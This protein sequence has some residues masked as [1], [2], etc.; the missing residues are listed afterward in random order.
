LSGR[1]GLLLV[2]QA[3]DNVNNVTSQ[4]V[5]QF[6]DLYDVVEAAPEPDKFTPSVPQAYDP[7]AIA[8]AKKAAEKEA[9]ERERLAKEQAKE[10]ERLAEI[11]AQQL[12]E[13]GRR[14][15]DMELEARDAEVKAMR[16]G[17]QKTIEEIELSHDKELVAITRWYEDLRQKRIDEAKK[18]YDAQKANEGK[19]FFESEEYKKASSDEAYTEQEKDILA[20]KLKAASDVY[21]HALEDITDADR[22]AMINYLSEYG[23]YQEK[24]LAIAEKYDDMISKAMTEGERKSLEK[25]KNEAL[26]QLDF[27]YLQKE[28]DWS[29]IFGDLDRVATG[30]LKEVRAQLQLLKK[31]ANYYKRNPDQIKVIEEAINRIN[32]ELAEK[33]GLFGGLIDSFKVY[34]DA[35]RAVTEAEEQ[36]ANALTD[37]EK[38]RARQGLSIAKQNLNSASDTKDKSVDYTI[39]KTKSL[40]GVITE[41]GNTEELSVAQLG[42][43]IS[44]TTDIFGEAAGKIGGIIGAILAILDSIGNQDIDE[45]AKRM[46]NKVFNAVGQAF[47]S[48]YSLLHYVA[49]DFL[50]A[51]ND[52]DE[53]IPKLITANEDLEAAIRANTEALEDA[54]IADIASVY[55]NAVSL[56]NEREKNMRTIMQE[57]GSTYSSGFLGLGGKH[58]AFSHIDELMN[59]SEWARISKIVGKQVTSAGGFFTLSSE[60]MKKVREQASD[61][62]SK[63]KNAGEDGFAGIAQYMDEYIEYFEEFTA[64]QEKYFTK[65]TTVSLD[66]VVEDFRSSL[67][68]MDTNASDFADKF[69]EYMRN[70]I[71][72][73]LVTNQ[74]EPM[75]KDW[76]E[77]FAK[78]VETDGIDEAE[79]AALQEQWDAITEEGLRMRDQLRDQFGLGSTGEGSGL[80]KAVSSFSQEQGDELNGRLA[81][82]QIG[83]QYAN[84]QLTMAI[85]SLQGLSVVASANSGTIVE[86]RNLMLIGN[87]HLEDIARYTRIAAQ[88]GDAIEQIATK[89]KEL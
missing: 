87:S 36:L 35:V 32:A 29:V 65:L 34:E 38:E 30:E 7:K 66:S 15:V 84:E 80:Y 68:D 58:S 72:N 1:K 27:D 26:S 39:S 50:G 61:L 70:A 47:D 62:Y 75:L 17:T 85:A 42:N 54:S 10:R 49:G 33:G 3:M 88:Y 31:D 28:M 23:T 40:M 45:W 77:A 82:I 24:R 86:M 76:Y 22:A 2:A 69:E 67:A 56:M 78:A 59:A 63:I 5:K 13:E 41:L 60:D 48:K 19:N 11:Y 25:Q 71:I 9:K 20:R 6:E 14:N 73:A 21:N 55:E 44:K 46:A 79:R 8:A 83:Q 53:S 81:A 51:S 12:T 18:V 4:A 89:I 37:E 64:L 57:T 52:L 43:L 74:F 16:D